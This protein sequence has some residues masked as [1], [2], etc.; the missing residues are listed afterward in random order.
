MRINDC[1]TDV[2]VTEEFLNRADIITIFKQMR[3]KRMAKRVRSPR[4]IYSR[5]VNGLFH[6]L[7]QNGFMHMVSALL[8]SELDR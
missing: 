8:S 4:F 6:S 5:L 3:C 1:G 7:L 2:T